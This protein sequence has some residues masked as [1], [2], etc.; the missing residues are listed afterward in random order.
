MRPPRDAGPTDEEL[1]A[2]AVDAFFAGV[3]PP[4]LDWEGVA[5]RAAR[6]RG[7]RR[8]A[9]LAGGAVAATAAALLVGGA[10]VAFAP[11][12]GAHRPALSTP[13]A[14]PRA[15]A[16]A[17]QPAAAPDIEWRGRLYRMGAPLAS[18]SGWRRLAGRPSLARRAALAFTLRP[19]A[20]YGRGRE[21]AVLAAADGGAPR[22]WRL[23]PLSP[24]PPSG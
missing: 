22:L 8:R 2:R 6:L 4:P 5:A 24:R 9:A 16:G 23:E 7:G 3:D 17:M 14:G 18:A 20:V 19:L 11:A 15:Y 21:R 10:R 13:A 12:P 1:A